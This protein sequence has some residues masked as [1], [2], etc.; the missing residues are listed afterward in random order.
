MELSSGGLSLP[1]IERLILT[2]WWLRKVPMLINSAL[3][4]WMMSLLLRRGEVRESEV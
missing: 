2:D 4:L 1:L 3:F